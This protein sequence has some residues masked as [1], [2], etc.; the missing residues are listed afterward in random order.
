MDDR[1]PMSANRR[2]VLQGAA[3]LVPLALVPGMARAAGTPDRAALKKAVDDQREDTIK[4]IQEWIRNP[5]I[6]AEGLN[7]DKGAPYMA[8]LARDAG[9]DH[10][11]VVKTGGV[12]GVFATLDVGA[13][14]TLALYFMYD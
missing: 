10:A 3:A 12:P 14:K 6:A 8:E 7:V 11:E 9:F 5:T 13:P 4:L 1:N 2:D